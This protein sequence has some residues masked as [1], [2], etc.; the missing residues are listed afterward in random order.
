VFESTCE[1]AVTYFAFSADSTALLFYTQDSLN[2][3]HFHA[4]DIKEK[5]FSASFKFPGLKTADC[6]Y[7]SS[8]KLVLCFNYEIEIW[9]YTGHTCGLL[10]RLAVEKPYNSVLFNQCTM[11]EDKQFLACCIV[12]VI[13]VYCFNVSNIHSPKQVFRGHHGRIEFCRFLKINRYLISYGIDGVVFLWDISES[14]A[15]AYTRM[16]EGKENIV[17]MAVSPE[18][19]RIVCFMTSG[20]V[21]MIKLSRLG[22]AL[23][24]ETSLQLQGDVALE[25]QIR[26]L[27]TEDDLSEAMNSSDSEE[28]ADTSDCGYL[29]ESD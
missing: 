25:S 21:H 3:S 8:D 28:D 15:V 24:A 10:T 1:F 22:A 12:D 17:S 29:Y 9:E 20:R 19:D 11:S 23:P 7:L 6:C 5:V 16:A 2:Y 14:K 18:E 13:L 27:S 4:W 26:I